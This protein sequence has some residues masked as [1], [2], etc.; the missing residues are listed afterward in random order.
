MQIHWR[1]IDE[2]LRPGQW[3]GLWC[4]VAGTPAAGVTVALCPPHRL[5]VSVGDVPLL[6]ARVEEDHMGYHWLR[7]T[8]S[9]PLAILAPIRFDHVEMRARQDPRDALRGWS[10]DVAQ[11][12][13]TSS[14]SPLQEGEWLLAPLLRG[15]A[16]D[17]LRRQTVADVVDLT[18]C[19]HVDWS[20]DDLHILPLRAFSSVDD[21]RVKAWRKVARRGA[22]PPLVLQWISGLCAYLLLDGH[23][24]LLAAH[25][26][27]MDAPVLTLERIAERSGV[28]SP[29][30]EAFAA[31]KMGSAPDGTS[32]AISTESSNRLL[33][34]AFVPERERQ[35]SRAATLAGGVTRWEQEVRVQAGCRGAAPAGMLDPPH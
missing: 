22:L 14:A 9:G 2:R 32:R 18:D 6:W 17:R 23:D 21:G 12:L 13:A 24:R 25:L 3:E 33:L 31:S 16:G 10:R 30:A 29:M 8:Q 28:A 27:G 5:R 34:A 19:G 4:T 11:A 15:G 20:H 26:E 7:A 1:D 35:P